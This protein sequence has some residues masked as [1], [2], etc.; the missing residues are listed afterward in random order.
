[1]NDVQKN[2]LK[3]FLKLDFENDWF[4][5]DCFK[6]GVESQKAIQ[7]CFTR[8]SN[9]TFTDDARIIF[10]CAKKCVYDDGRKVVGVPVCFIKEE[11]KKVLNK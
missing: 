9:E 6:T 11:I 2:L 4:K 7:V 3:D 8:H 5:I 10:W 1:M